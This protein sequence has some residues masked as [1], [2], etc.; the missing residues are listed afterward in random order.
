MTAYA[1]V[2]LHYSNCKAPKNPLGIFFLPLLLSTRFWLRALCCN[3]QPLERPPSFQTEPPNP[4]NSTRKMTKVLPE[5][6]RFG[7]AR[8]RAVNFVALLISTSAIYL[9]SDAY[10]RNR[11]ANP[12]LRVKSTTF[13]RPHISGYG[14]TSASQPG[15][16]A[17]V[18]EP[19]EISPELPSV[20]ADTVLTLFHEPETN[21]IV[22]RF[23]G[24][25]ACPRPALM[26]RLSGPV[27]ILLQDWKLQ[28]TTSTAKQ[29]EPGEVLTTTMLEMRATY[30]VPVAG[31]YFLDLILLLCD[32]WTLQGP[33]ETEKF[34]FNETCIQDVT[35]HR[36][37][38][39]QRAWINIGKIHEVP[40]QLGYWFRKENA[41][42][43]LPLT[44]RVQPPVCEELGPHDPYCLAYTN[45]TVHDTFEFRFWDATT[46]S[47]VSVEERID[48]L[49]T[50][51]KANKNTDKLCLV[52]KSHSD[53]LARLGFENIGLRG[54]DR[55]KWISA[56]Y[57]K[58]LTT[59]LATNIQRQGCSKII[60]A[61]GQWSASKRLSHPYLVGEF[62]DGMTKGLK[63]FVQVFERDENVNI[64]FRSIDFNPLGYRRSA[65]PPADWR[66]PVTIAAYN[67]VLESICHS[68]KQC[69]FLDTR[70][71]Q[72]PM[73]DAALDF[74]HPTDK[75]CIPLAVYLASR[76]MGFSEHYEAASG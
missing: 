19:I 62:R 68:T 37:S 33:V 67:N 58:N 4:Y 31:K 50:Q 56:Q 2:T 8:L 15:E 35:N 49:Q 53:G 13:A 76:V 26:G 45:L 72:K 14:Y 9:I 73:W 11:E 3:L 5:E 66:D 28:T 34:D 44:T 10:Y 64:Y 12:N 23:E 21:S 59:K 52:G 47:T 54:E 55:L 51:I 27:A 65:C 29:Q 22:V 24:D 69:T 46:A 18:F 70:Q 57:P 61:V 75:V 63:N 48:F 25:L 60:V 6:P 42:P 32:D 1:Y 7:V 30:S 43:K 16:Q 39:P 17:S 41:D 36:I 71:I 74:N 38:H 40:V 20:F